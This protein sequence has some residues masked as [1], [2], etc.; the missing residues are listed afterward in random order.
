MK[1]EFSTLGNRIAI[2]T[3]R[4]TYCKVTYLTVEEARQTIKNILEMQRNWE[5][6]F[7]D[8]S[9]KILL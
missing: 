3:I 2:K 5:I 9:V 4:R 8:D 7:V 6:R 1:F